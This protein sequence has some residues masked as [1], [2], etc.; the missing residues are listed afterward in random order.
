MF[1]TRDYKKEKDLDNAID[2]MRNKYGNNTISRACFVNSNYKP[3]IGGVGED[4]DFM[5]M[6]SHL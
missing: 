1:D 2:R 6:N 5:M 4:G 3:M